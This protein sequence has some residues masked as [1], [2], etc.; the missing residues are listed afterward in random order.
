MSQNSDNLKPVF[1]TW[2]LVSLKFPHQ[3]QSNRV[4][5]RWG[6]M[7]DSHY[8]CAANKSAARMMRPCKYGPNCFHCLV[9]SMYWR[10]E[11]VLK[12]K[13]GLSPLYRPW[14]VKVYIYITNFYVKLSLLHQKVLKLLEVTRADISRIADTELGNYTGL[15]DI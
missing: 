5:L 3:S 2:Q 11:A 15:S 8:G 14:E 10:T 7:G 9:E 1:W 4:S 13:W 6:R 12:P